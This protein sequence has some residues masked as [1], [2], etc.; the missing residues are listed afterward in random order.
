VASTEID[1]SQ[2][3]R[4]RILVNN[5]T[6]QFGQDGRLAWRVRTIA[7]Q[8]PYMAARPDA[9]LKLA[10][11]PISDNDLLSH[12]GQMYGMETASSISSD[13]QKYSPSIQRSIFSSLTPGQQ[14]T[15]VQMGYEVPKSDI[16]NGSWF[17][18]V[19][20]PL[21]KPVGW[22]VGGVGKPLMGVVSPALQLLDTV[23]DTMV[24]RPY[25]TIR[26]LDSPTQILAAI[27]GIAGGA[28]A[29]ALAPAT[30]GGSLGTFAALSVAGLGAV[31]GASATAVG[32][33]TLLGNG[34]DWTNAWSAAGNGERLFKTSGIKKAEETLGDPRLV[35]LAQQFAESMDDYSLIDIARDVAGTSNSLNQQQQLQEINTVAS[36]FAEEGTEEHSKLVSSLTELLAQPLFQD[37]VKT[38]VQSKI[39]I[40]RDIAGIAFDED[41]SAY[42][43]I[44]GGI[45]AATI[46][47]IDPF[48]LAGKVAHG[49]QFARRGLQ[50]MDGAV[51]V[52]RV[53]KVAELPEMKKV[54]DLVAES[55]NTGNIRL[56]DNYAPWMKPAYDELRGWKYFNDDLMEAG[57]LLGT[58]KSAFTGEDVVNWI[59]DQNN[60]KSIMSGTGIINGAGKGTLRGLNKTQY[61]M[62]TAK[63]SVKE[64]FRGVDEV[65]AQTMG[66]GSRL[67]KLLPKLGEATPEA[68]KYS[69]KNLTRQA[70]DNPDFMKSLLDD[71]PEEA[72]LNPH[73]IDAL[74]PKAF[75]AGA[76][77]ANIPGIKSLGALFNGMR[78]MVPGRHISLAG[79]DAMQEIEQLV[80]LFRVAN[81]PDSVRY[82][83]KKTILDAPDVGARLNAITSMYDSFFRASGIGMSD[84]VAEWA[85]TFLKGIKQS[86]AIGPNG[87]VMT[88]GGSEINRA[89]LPFV[90]NAVEISIPDLHG[91]RK[92]AAQG[93]LMR[94][95]VGIPE[96]V[97]LQYFQ[98]RIWKP[99]VLLRYGFAVKNS[100]EDLTS[101]VSRAGIGHMAQ[102]FS[103]RNVAKHELFDDAIQ[104]SIKES[105]LTDQ[106][107]NALLKN[108]AIPRHMRPVQRIVE[109]FTTVGKPFNLQLQHY[110]DYLYEK[111][112]NGFGS[113]TINGWMKEI[114]SIPSD[115]TKAF[116]F[117]PENLK[118][119]FNSNIKALV[120]GN[121]YSSRRMMMG[122]V[123]VD[124]I[125]SARAFEK[126]YAKSLMERIGTS[127][128]LPGQRQMTGE[129]LFEN[130]VGQKSNRFSGRV[131]FLH[132]NGERG[133]VR[134]NGPK[135]RLLQDGH[136]AVLESVT[137]LTDDPAGALF[138][139]HTQR[140]LTQNIL[141]SIPEDQ[142]LDTVVEWK[143]I[144]D[145][146]A[147]EQMPRDADDL[148]HMFMVLNEKLANPLDARHR[149]DALTK[150]LKTTNS[151]LNQWMNNINE[152]FGGLRIPTWED[153]VRLRAGD[154]PV[155]LNYLKKLEG[156]YDNF[157][158]TVSDDVARQW[159]FANLNLDFA[160]RGSHLSRTEIDRW[161]SEIKS[162]LGNVNDFG[163]VGPFY[164]D[165]EVALTNGKNEFLTKANEGQGEWANLNRN[166]DFI[167]VAKG[168]QARV[169]LFP[170]LGDQPIDSTFLRGHLTDN[171]G[172]IDV[173]RLASEVFKL[174]PATLNLTQRKALQGIGDQILDSIIR[175]NELV[176]TGFDNSDIYRLKAMLNKAFGQA[177]YP[178]IPDVAYARLP[179]KQGSDLT[180]G[181][182]VLAEKIHNIRVGGKDGR[183]L[184]V[185]GWD[186]DTYPLTREYLDEATAIGGNEK[187]ADTLSN[188]VRE[189]IK[190]GRRSEW[191]VAPN[192]TLYR[193][194]NGR[195]VE[196]P[197]NTVIDSSDTYYLDAKMSKPVELGNQRYI[198]SGPVTFE[199]NDEIL[200][201]IVSPVVY[202]HAELVTG[203]ML[204]VPKK[205]SQIDVI[206]IENIDGSMTPSTM[207]FGYDFDRVR[208]SSVSDVSKTDAGMLP[209]FEVAKIYEPKYEN[210]WDRFVQYGFNNVLGATI[211][212]VA[213]RPMA[214]HAFHQ[215]HVRNI[216]SVEW[217]FKGSQAET[218][219]NNTISTLN[220][221][222]LFS[223]N[224]PAQMKKFGQVGRYAGEVEGLQGVEQWSDREAFAFLK[225]FWNEAEPDELTT[226]VNRLRNNASKDLTQFSQQQAKALVRWFER[227]N[228]NLAISLP[229]NVDAW[230]FVDQIDVWF[231]EGAALAGKVTNPRKVQ[232]ISE[233]RKVYTSLNPDDWK[234]IREAA[235]AKKLAYTNAEEYAAEYAIR[236]TMPFIDS[237]EF[238]SQFSE[239]G[240]GFLPFWYAQEN[241]LKRWGKIFTLDGPLGTLAQARKMQLTYAGLKTSGVLREDAQGKSYFVYPGSDLLIEAVG[242]IPGLNLLPVQAMLQTPADRLIPGFE[243]N[244][245]AAG[246]S[247][248]IGMPMDM[249]QSLFPESESLRDLQ[250]AMFGE[251]GSNR[252]FYDYILPA[253]VKNTFEAMRLYVDSNS[254]KH[255]E[256]IGSS[257]MAAMA[258]LEASGN[259][260]QDGATPGEVDE[261]LRRVRNH[262]RTIVMS[263]A[264]AGWFTPGPASGLQTTEDQNSV[265]WLTEGA[266]KNPA[267]LLSSTYYTLVQKLGIEEGTVRYLELYPDN[268]VHD[269]IN[270]L[271]YTV[272]KTATRSGAP[273]PSTEQSINFYF[274]NQE[275][276]NQYPE[277]GAW[278][279]PPAKEG[280]TR[281][282]YA[283]DNEVIEGLRVKKTPEEFLNEVKYKE[284]ANIYFAS[285]K[286]YLDQYEALKDAGQKS[287]AAALKNAWDAQSA[288]FRAAHP[289]FNEKLTSSDARE[290]RARTITQMRYLLNDPEAPQAEHFGGLRILMNSFDTFVTNKGSLGLDQ[291]ARGRAVLE[292]FKKQFEEW[293]NQFLLDYPE[294]S[295]FWLTVI[296]PETGLD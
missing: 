278:L 191:Y 48:I 204:T 291:S 96:S 242:K 68:S 50:W 258:H 40:G 155:S 123:N 137:R 259:G 2:L 16:N 184:S 51:S 7:N 21:A 280:D 275:L 228:G 20:G 116:S 289:I 243:A 76:F 250:T 274:D 218:N 3:D 130:N 166:R 230:D 147:V 99:A 196:I 52:E 195:A 28:A 42:R 58:P 296:R 132:I 194:F 14:N 33:E 108:Y 165:L 265:E 6:S 229:H 214:F 129:E 163:Q 272:S 24:F 23:S 26:Q 239:W 135:S 65:A 182:P 85:D 143:R 84:D 207:D 277:A 115:A 122:G 43:W 56:L 124:L 15:L 94:A 266:V 91:I 244:I 11:M 60:L 105:R 283:Y 160:T 10:Q 215:A 45:D 104:K 236:D 199:G 256:K 270:P 1:F 263:Q 279:L 210:T 126:T 22:A 153:A 216:K 295:T 17:D 193:N 73:L 32:S 49:W 234:T 80:D 101:Y 117:A 144:L 223:V 192:Q 35:N 18:D 255:N 150:K 176:L 158:A 53:R 235:E 198:L 167:P 38:L 151:T 79:P 180:D 178:Q 54:F 74:N 254:A 225:G 249:V 237:H 264:L 67:G 13:I 125:E 253:Q 131:D 190:A 120:L 100:M 187:L 62:R 222:Q 86:Y 202:D 19:L 111:L 41:S 55:V 221:K 282:K 248:L 224:G 269:I 179:I 118:A 31:A 142:L 241:F 156:F 281:S 268:R 276:L 63:G 181:Y 119:N 292:V 286:D 220:G 217:L 61:A 219:L 175:R 134:V 161:A 12:A 211:D 208:T 149:I 36:K 200:W 260:L 145:I 69:L 8:N 290:R 183:T 168:T 284:G 37:A 271:A 5:I 238:R 267:E 77:A 9:V 159:L 66:E 285:R 136:S 209:D 127:R 287:Q 188:A 162:G 75:D 92:A 189:R 97:P 262:A 141:K 29:L 82:V 227:N 206:P 152:E 30:F 47:A 226:F 245:G 87:R 205:S 257:M 170:R 294:A 233:V 246:L 201:S 293:S 146:K 185:V 90:D 213:R 169:M 113:K 240:R 98:G 252:A 138:L 186:Q 251:A 81:V 112:T 106:E 261:Y 102:E 39:S 93:S 95:L 128:L 154:N 88:A 164:N 157:I 197:G 46:I 107:A 140:V 44:S 109:K 64:F 114:D 232:N 171:V 4:D 172:N 133:V 139:G 273:L 148:M 34:L 27:G 173:D 177:G 70:S 71:L 174:D 78:T 72:R 203:R 110:N 247:P 103:A 25:R 288:I 89:V 231:G 83:W 212:A 57:L 59:V 121:P